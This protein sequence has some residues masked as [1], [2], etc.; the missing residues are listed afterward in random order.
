MTKLIAA[1]PVTGRLILAAVM[2]MGAGASQAPAQDS[3]E[4]YAIARG[5]YGRRPAASQQG[6]GFVFPGFSLFGGARRDIPEVT[7]R[8]TAPQSNESQGRT[9]T[10]ENVAGPR[11]YCVRTCDGFFFPAGPAMSGEGRLAQQSSCSA[12]CPGAEVA[13]YTIARQGSIEDAVGPQGRTYSA[14]RTAFRF[15]QTVDRACTCQ[16]AATNGLARLP[17]TRDFTLRAG[18]VVVTESGV[19]VFRGAARFP[20]RSQDFVEAR[21]YGR[22][23]ADIRR[24]VAEIQAGIQARDSGTAAPVARTGRLGAIAP[25]QPQP[26][27]VPAVLDQTPV[28]AASANAPVRVLDITRPAAASTLQ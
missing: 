18:D 20:Y 1:T 9:A 13:L 7:V 25:A 14:L 16:G 11:A 17:I 27:A 8:P 24:R 6:R 10:G 21:T 22:L 28:T 12:M 26:V 3:D 23:P 4:F 15:R 2:L 19:R 5:E